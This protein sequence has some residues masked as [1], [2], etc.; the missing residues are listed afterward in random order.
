MLSFERS[1]RGG[2]A[3]PIVMTLTLDAEMINASQDIG[4]GRFTISGSGK[5]Q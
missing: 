5:K 2:N 1:G 4:G 3:F